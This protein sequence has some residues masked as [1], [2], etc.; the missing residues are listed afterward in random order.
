MITVLTA[1]GPR[2]E[3]RFATVLGAS[4]EVTIARRC[5]DLPDLIACAAAGLGQVAVV[6]ADMRGLDLNVVDRL[7]AEGCAVV[8]VAHTGESD[9]RWLRQLDVDAVVSGNCDVSDTESAIRAAW[10]RL[11]AN[12]NAEAVRRR[13]TV[14][15]QPEV[16]APTEDRPG[17]AADRLARAG[18]DDG[19]HT[20]SAVESGDVPGSAP[21]DAD[22]PA[23]AEP[24]P[25]GEPDQDDPDGDRPGRLIAVWGPP[26]SPGRT[27]VAVN[28]AAELA[29]RGVR[30]LLVDADT[31]AASAAQVLALLDEAPGLAAACRHAEQGHL[32]V[33]GLSRL[34]PEVEPGMRVLTGIPRAQRWTE[35]RDAALGRVLEL[36]RRLADVV[37]VDIASA[38]DHDEELS[39]DTLAPRR[40]GAARVTLD[41][42]DE[43]IVVG[44][45]DPVGL[46]RLVRGLEEL[47][48]VR[49]GPPR[50]VINRVRPGAV[51]PHPEERI[52]QALERFAGVKV[53]IYIPEDRDVLDTALLDGRTLAESAPH[54]PARKAIRD[55]A[56]VVAGLERIAPARSRRVR[57]PGRRRLIPGRS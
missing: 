23:D 4:R 21:W 50:V 29:Q 25:D 26:G 31:Y 19:W 6:S 20:G 47:A 39:Y 49:P 24:A 43:V 2:L 33:A 27:T 45:A 36:S 7:R 17:A 30:T 53:E 54:A 41:K 35:I 9:D 51:G 1:I 12:P 56:Q 48:E 5:A 52:A 32:D 8:G 40:N 10:V 16:A 38:L 11:G 15:P 42:C 28:L 34:A 3:T 22:S 44:A 13:R 18:G 46:G 14:A 57:V 55:L 37:I